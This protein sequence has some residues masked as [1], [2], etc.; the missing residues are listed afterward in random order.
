M[1]AHLNGKNGTKTLL[2]GVIVLLKIAAFLH[3]WVVRGEGFW[4]KC[5]PNFT[6]EMAEEFARSSASIICWV[7]S[8]F[9]VQLPACN[10]H[11]EVQSR[12]YRVFLQYFL[13]KL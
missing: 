3:Q 5:K 2:C 9:V 6:W 10:F 1:T 12:R 8:L 7:F 11:S 4:S 13:Q